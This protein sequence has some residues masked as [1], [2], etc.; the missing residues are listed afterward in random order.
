MKKEIV[1]YE[2]WKGEINNNTLVQTTI[3][4]KKQFLF[5]PRELLYA[6]ARWLNTQDPDKIIVKLSK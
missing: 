4:E 3:N 5:T 1:D 6:T 2:N